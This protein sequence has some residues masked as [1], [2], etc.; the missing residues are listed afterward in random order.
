MTT[1]LAQSSYLT[2][3]KISEL[4]GIPRRTVYDYLSEIEKCD[5]Y[6]SAWVTLDGGRAKLVN[7]LV[8]E[9]FL[10]YRQSL[11]HKNLARQLPPYDPKVVKRQRGE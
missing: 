7:L 6:R 11:K 8:L 10:R 9:D 2:I 3:S 4:Y 1:A 5:R